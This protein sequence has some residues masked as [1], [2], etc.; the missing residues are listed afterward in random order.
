M[1]VG[2][3]SDCRYW[4]GPY[5]DDDFLG[6]PVPLSLGEKKALTNYQ[7]QTVL[8]TLSILQAVSSRRRKC[9]PSPMPFFRGVEV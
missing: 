9:S 2:D 5:P 8:A 3:K 4:N 6:I 1:V 7:D